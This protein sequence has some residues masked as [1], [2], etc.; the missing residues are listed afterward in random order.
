MVIC[1]LCTSGVPTLSYDE[2]KTE[3]S[4]KI[5]SK[6]QLDVEYSGVPTP[7]ITWTFDGKPI[8]EELLS[9]MSSSTQVMVRKLERSHSGIYSVTAENTVGR[10]T[11]SFTLDVKGNLL[12]LLN[13]KVFGLME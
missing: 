2:N 7:T 9:T 13:D 11:A 8:D 1:T 12:C 10:A 5:A 3:L 4:S 6:Y